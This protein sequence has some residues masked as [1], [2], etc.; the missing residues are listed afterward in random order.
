MKKT[1]ELGVNT[2]GEVAD[3]CIRLRFRFLVDVG[4]AHDPR[5]YVTVFSVAAVQ[6][7][8]HYLREVA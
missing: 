2:A 7:V 6:A 1:F 5:R 4:E 3:L 8:E